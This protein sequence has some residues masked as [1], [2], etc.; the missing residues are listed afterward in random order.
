M[1]KRMRMKEWQKGQE[2]GTDREKRK[3]E[4]ERLIGIEVT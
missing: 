3:R 2:R 4:G 1:I